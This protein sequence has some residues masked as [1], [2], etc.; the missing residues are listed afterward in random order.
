MQQ[1]RKYSMKKIYLHIGTAKTGSSALQAFFYK[2][3]KL[4]EDNGIYYPLEYGGIPFNNF[5][6][7][8]GNLGPLILEKD[9]HDDC[10][11]ACHNEQRHDDYLLKNPVLIGIEN[12]DEFPSDV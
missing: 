4:L 7:S 2:N 3:A 5:L 9:N 1:G 12:P 11:P 8:G 10:P 6:L